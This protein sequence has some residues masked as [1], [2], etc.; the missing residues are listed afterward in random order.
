MVKQAKPWPMLATARPLFIPRT[1]QSNENANSA[2]NGIPRSQKRAR[3]IKLAIF[4]RPSA[5]IRPC[6]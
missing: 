3:A 4:C 5:R 2:A 1:P 6:I